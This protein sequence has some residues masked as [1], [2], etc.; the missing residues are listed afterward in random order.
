MNE[1]ITCSDDN[2]PPTLSAGPNGRVRPTAAGEHL[3]GATARADPGTSARNGSDQFQ[4]KADA[5]SITMT[6]CLMHSRRRFAVLK[7]APKA[8]ITSRLIHRAAASGSP[9]VQ[10]LNEV[11]RVAQELP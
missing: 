2:F 10:R 1:I 3:S 9:L 5:L 4:L 7:V 8:A 6:R 11:F